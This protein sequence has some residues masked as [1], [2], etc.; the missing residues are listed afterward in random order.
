[1]G[2]LR[3]H[4]STRPC[5]HASTRQHD[6]STRERWTLCT[7]PPIL[8]LHACNKMGS[9]PG[10]PRKIRQNQKEKKMGRLTRPR[11]GS[12]HGQWTLCTQPPC[13]GLHACNK[14]GSTPVLPRKKRQSQQK[15]LFFL[16]G[17]FRPLPNKN[18]QFWDHFFQELFPKDFESQKNLD[19]RLWENL[20]K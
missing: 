4:G 15:K 7:H 1:M 17:N 9:I 8:G 5:I 16:G 20:A 14:M 19:I 10:L 2:G 12:T 11:D 3:I 6:G 18:V 13:L